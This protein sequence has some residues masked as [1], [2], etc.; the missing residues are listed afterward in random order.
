[1]VV[2]H[3][4]LTHDMELM[5]VLSDDDVGCVGCRDCTVI[6]LSL[7]RMSQPAFSDTIC[8]GSFKQVNSRVYVD[9]IILPSETLEQE[10]WCIITEYI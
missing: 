6:V 8:L 4:S 1:M 3:L 2:V 9:R 7:K 5:V 10:R